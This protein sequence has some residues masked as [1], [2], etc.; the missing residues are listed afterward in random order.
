MKVFTVTSN[1]LK[2]WDSIKK[3]ESENRWCDPVFIRVCTTKELINY[4]F[5][6]QSGMII[7]SDEEI[8]AENI[9][10]EQYLKYIKASNGNK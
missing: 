7:H 2:V 1:G 10:H 6:Y 9:L 5:P 3:F 8:K 4:E